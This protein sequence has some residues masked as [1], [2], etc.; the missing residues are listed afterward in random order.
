MWQEVSKPIVILSEETYINDK[1]GGTI[2]L[3]CEIRG[4]TYLI[5]FKTSKKIHTTQLIQLGGYLNLL[6]ELDH[7]L[8]KKIDRCQI[9]S[10]TPDR[11][12]TEGRER[13][14]MKRYETI[15]ENSY[16]LYSEYDRL[17][18][19][20]WGTSLRELKIIGEM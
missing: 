20:E 1:Y 15:F 11:I 13:K 3:I 7:E 4:L 16:I 19:E 9:I 18:K 14:Q 10:F 2:D 5:D 17:L 12:I 8:Y 6:S